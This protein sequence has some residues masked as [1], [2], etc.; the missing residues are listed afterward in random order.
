MSDNSNNIDN[1]NNINLSAVRNI[2]SMYEDWFL[3]YASYVI[4]ERAIPNIEDGLKPVQ[5]RILYSMN[6]MDDGRYHKVANII[7]TTMQLHPHGDKAI[8][9]ALVNLGQKNL[10]I[11][12]QGNWGDVRT[13]DKSAAPRYIEARLTK[14]AK[15]IAFNNNIT[16][17]QLSYDGRKDE[18]ITLPV[19]FP[20]LLAHGAEGIAVGLSTKILPHNFPELIKASIQ[21]LRNKSFTIYP[22]FTT[23]GTMDVKHYNN[24]KKGGR[25]RARATIEIDD[26]ET[27]IIKSIPYGITTSNLIDSIVRANN[28]GK[29]KIKNIQDN[30]AENIE[31][32][33]KIVKGVSPNLTIDALYAFTNC[34]ISIAPNCCVI[35]NNKPTFISTNELLK[36]STDNTMLILEK[37]L[38]YSLK[39]L[40]Q[41]WHNVTLEKIFI[42]NRIYIKIEECTTWNEVIKTI[43]KE[44]FL[45]RS[46]LKDKITE[47]DILRLTEIKIKRISKYD[48]NKHIDLIKRINNDI[49]EVKNNL[50]NLIKYGIRFFEHLNKNYANKIKRSTEIITFDTISARRVAAAT[51]KLYVNKA[52][53]FIGFILKKDD[54]VCKCSNIDNVIVFLEDGSYLV[55]KV[56]NKKY[57]GKNILHIDIWKKNNKHMIYNVIYKNYETKITYIKRFAVTSV[58]KDKVYSLAGSSKE[59]K[60]LYLT[61]NPNS[62]SE[63]VNI[64][65]HAKAKAKSKVFEYDFSNILIKG[66][67]TKGNILSKYLIRKI[68]QKTLGES[69]LGGVDIWLDENIGRLNS[70]NRG[71]YLGSFNSEDR[72]VLFFND[73]SHEMS[74]F[75]ISNR[76][77]MSDLQVIEKYNSDSKYCIIYKDGKTKKYFVKR[78][79]IGTSVVGRRYSLISESRGSKLILVSKDSGLIIRFDYRLNNGEKKHKEI[80]LDTYI[81]IKGWKAKGKILDNK[82]RMSAFTFISKDYKQKTQ[83]KVSLN[84]QKNADNSELTLF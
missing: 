51:N 19:K 47:D 39:I 41:K 42:E 38:K 58:I 84:K 16:K 3:E 82:K 18:P 50:N 81:D 69:T 14:F 37:E 55:T 62:E 4:L 26:K 6:E 66:K 44:T 36:Y 43:K 76:Y 1:I 11:D 54:F 72:I 9:D 25:I 22:D 7:G 64:Y 77:N 75:D 53:G 8:G 5:R 63:I 74:T 48:K 20:L 31:I 24:G 17:Y 23:G 61:A 12:T 71:K 60:V 78:F 45:H 28:S 56:D 2:S 80:L 65:L 59:S 68:T 21:Y 13:G 33:I 57:I 29:I 15:E 35:V 30:T 40:Q 73:G 27:L 49:E 10:L 32:V 52:E 83:S 46:L 79:K 67:N 34:E 70:E